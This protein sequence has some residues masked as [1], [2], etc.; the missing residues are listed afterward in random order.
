MYVTRYA[1][2][3]MGW[4]QDKVDEVLLPV[5]K[6]MNTKEPQ[7][8]ISHYFSSSPSSSGSGLQQQQQRKSIK[9]QRI[10]NVV[11][12]LTSEGDC[13]LCTVCVYNIECTCVDVCSCTHNTHCLWCIHV[14]MVQVPDSYDLSVQRYEM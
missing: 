9:S 2:D 7:K 13:V 10:R 11:A 6:R 1:L 5:L 12:S 3:K 14:T 4:A 8:K